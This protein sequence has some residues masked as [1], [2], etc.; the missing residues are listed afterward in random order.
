MEKLGRKMDTTINSQHM[1]D[2]PKTL[3]EQKHE[4]LQQA[5]KKQKR[6]HAGEVNIT[7]KPM[8]PIR[9]TTYRHG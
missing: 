1:G 8:L 3:A 7:S 5:N 9:R 2:F 6:H 4:H